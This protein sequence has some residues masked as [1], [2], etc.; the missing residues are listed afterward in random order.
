MLLMCGPKPD[1]DLKR[2]WLGYYRCEVPKPKVPDAGLCHYSELKYHRSRSVHTGF[3][4][5]DRADR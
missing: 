2:V 4:A 1:V 3:L 5:M